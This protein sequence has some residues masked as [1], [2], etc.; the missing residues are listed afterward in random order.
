MV[1]DRSGSMAALGSGAPSSS[2]MRPKSRMDLAIEGAQRALL[3]LRPGDAVGVVAFDY[4]ARWVSTVSPIT[5]QDSLQRIQEQVAQIRPD[6][7]TDLYRAI[8]AAYQ[9]LRAV[10]AQAKHIILLTDGE[11]GSPAPFELLVRALQGQG[12]SLST[13]GLLTSETAHALLTDLA[14]QGKGRF[15]AVT[16]PEDLPTVLEQEAIT[17]VNLVRPSGPLAA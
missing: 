11:Q 7:G 9:G 13:V 17:F 12:I 4:T 8:E 14:T 3:S 16:A 5:D 1:L 2:G 15:H 6:G 10:A